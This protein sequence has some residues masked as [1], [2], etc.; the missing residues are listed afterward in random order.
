MKKLSTVFF[1]ILMPMMS[2]AQTGTIKARVIDAKT[3][4]PLYKAT[5]VITETKQGAYTQ[6]GGY[7]TIGKVRPGSSYTLTA[8]FAGYEAEIK[9]EV[10]VKKDDTTRLTFKLKTALQ[11]EIIVEA[12]PMFDKTETKQGVRTNSD[13]ISNTPTVTNID[14]LTTLT[15]GVV[16]D[17][18]NGG[19][20]VGGARGT[21]NSTR[22][23]GVE[24]TDIVN[25]QTNL[26]QNNVSKMSVTEFSV[27][28]S[29][30]DASRGNAIG[31]YIVSRGYPDLSG[32]NHARI[33]ENSFHSAQFDPLSTFSIDVDNASYSL[34]RNYIEQYRQQ[35]PQDAVRIEEMINYF[36]YD[37]PQPKNEH[38]FSVTTEIT[39]CFWNPSH[40]LMLIGLQG[41]TIPLTEMP[42]SNIVFLIDVSGS[43]RGA[44]RL[45]LV[46]E[47][48]KLL[49][50]ALR[51]E[52]RIAIVVYAGSAG[53]V[54]P[55][56]S[57]N[58]KQAI[59]NALDRLQAG[60]STAGGA[61]IQLAYKTALDNFIKNGNNRVILCTD[62]DFNVGVSSE[63]ELARLIEEKR[64]SG[65][66]LTAL[67]Y[68]MG[69]YKDNRLEQLADKGNGN[70]AYIDNISEAKKWLIAQMTGTLYTIAKDVKLQLEFN[71][72][73]IKGYRLI[74]Y[75]N[76]VLAKEDFNNDKKDAGE[77]GAGHSVTALY[78][79]IPTGVA[80]S[81][82]DSVDELKY[83]TVKPTE[84]ATSNQFLSVKLRYKQPQDTTSKFFAQAV[85]DGNMIS[86][87]QSSGNLRFASSVAMFGM[88]LR[89]SEHK[90]SATLDDALTTAKYSLGKDENGYRAEF[91]KLIEGYKLL[92]KAA[93]DK[94]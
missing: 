22:M 75:E 65:I 73:K 46:K 54:L 92:N 10:V 27:T 32:N 53:L 90:G 12:K 9:K 16:P 43:M 18:T 74:G 79:L 71:P 13:A 47:S 70:Y 1:L 69:N 42:P 80:Y 38:P 49:T 51:S 28:T 4:E 55:S 37:Y 41:K 29:G 39:D 62:G 67:G 76:R 31:G 2:I 88:I 89:G 17:G 19:F 8:K 21:T 25:G 15:P 6:K 34:V 63:G 85:T 60:G 11:K 36:S 81:G 7:A 23:G 87:S 83:Q 44:N 14:Q 5:V 26:I 78:E 3:D 24:I 77:L 84:A 68:G 40:K 59:L 61:G 52:D 91:I 86:Y 82:L 58:D 30:A 50:Q 66:Y 20:S 93:V 64:A 56:T 72:I 33:Y 35:P 94:Q 48:L 57:G 45:P